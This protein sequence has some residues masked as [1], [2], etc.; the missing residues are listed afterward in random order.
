MKYLLPLLCLLLNLPLFAQS[1]DH[2]ETIVYET[3]TWKYTTANSAPGSDWNLPDFDDSQWPSG[4]GGFGYGDN[5]DNTVIM[6]TPAVFLR[7]TFSIVELS[8]IE[9]LLLGMDYDDGFVAYI[10]GREVARANITGSPPAYNQY[11]P[12]DREATMYRTGRP[13]DFVLSMDTLGP[14]LNEGAN[15]LAIEVHNVSSG[16]S[17]LT[18]RAFLSAG[19]TDGSFTYRETPDWFVPPL[20][21]ESS[22]LPIVLIDTENGADIVDE[23]KV[24][25]RMRI[26]DNGTF[27][28]KSDT[29][30]IY[31]G[32]IGIEIRGRFSQTFPQKSY[33]L[34]TRDAQGDNN[35]V[36]L[37]DMPEENDWILLTNY[38]DKAFSRNALAFHI[39]QQMG[40]YAPRFKHCEV[41]INDQYRGVY[42]F[43]EKLKRDKNRIPVAKLDADDISGDKLTGGYIFKI[44]YYNA[45]DSWQGNYHPVDNPWA[46]VHFVY[47]DP[48][49][50]EL[51]PEQKQY[52]QSYINT[53]ESVLY[54]DDFA[55]PTTG[56][57]NYLDVGSFIDYFIVS[58]I[59]R[60][61]DAYKKSRFFFKHRNRDGGLIHSGPV[62]DF[63]WS[64]KNLADCSIFRATDGSGW[65]YQVNGACSVSP[66]PAGWMVRLMQ[67]ERFQEQLGNRYRQLRESYLSDAYLHHFID[68]I[69]L[70]VD[71]AQQRHYYTYP[72]LG[73]NTGAPEVDAIPN[74]FP[75]EVTKLKDWLNLRLAWLDANMPDITTTDVSTP[76]TTAQVRIFPN[77]TR[78]LLYVESGRI[79]QRIEL[80]SPSGEKI[81]DLPVSAYE[82]TVPLQTLPAGM[83][84]IKVYLQE[85]NWQGR[86]LVSR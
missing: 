77:P 15:L 6:I 18:A 11:T 27:N 67:D 61:V 42:L 31:D 32:P 54:G 34:E 1:I 48:K 44:D 16:S 66:S 20:S 55:D 28:R 76:S 79:I 29:P 72:T 81:R 39:F 19:I 60:N 8:K 82:K 78:D 59:S 14:Y 4:P 56:Y 5:D 36:P 40:H 53:F 71:T 23:P 70:L 58:E 43:T 12:T 75:G 7:T 52:I 25:A 45:E 35:N 3:D 2:W 38:N 68:S 80:Y 26:M 41:F 83:Y 51:Q 64:F 30:Q 57:A 13:T 65:A 37:W 86:F 21:F 62:W 50:E 69:A 17:D 73:K 33:G 47:H 46:D 9:Q 74:T 85:G 10:N 84:V 49:P 63:D 22:N 24:S